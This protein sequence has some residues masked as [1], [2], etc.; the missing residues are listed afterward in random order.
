VPIRDAADEF[1]SLDKC[2]MDQ[3]QKSSA[4][5]AKSPMIR[6]AA[7]TTDAGLSAMSS[8]LAHLDPAAGAGEPAAFA[9]RAYQNQ[10]VQ[11][12]LGIASGLFA[13]LRARHAPT[14][15]HSLRVALGCSSWAIFQDISDDERD[16]IEVAALLHDL[17][18]VGVPD[19]ILIKPGRLTAEESRIMDRHRQMGWEILQTC[20]VSPLL[21]SIMRNCGARFD[22][23]RPGYE[24]QGEELPLG[25]RM[26]AIVDAFDAMTN[27]QIYR[28]ALSR[29]RSIAEL[30]EHAGSQFDPRL[31]KDFCVFIGS[32]QATLQTAVAHRWLKQLQASSS[33]KMWLLRDGPLAAEAEHG[34]SF[35]QQLLENMHDAVIFV[36]HSQRILLWNRA[37][38]RLTGISTASV[39]QQ[40]WSPELI[41][42]RD[43]SRQPVSAVNCPLFRAI[44][45]GQPG[46][47][48]MTIAGRGSERLDVDAHVVPVRNQAGVGQ[49][50]ALLLHDASSQISL[51]Q[52]VLSLHEKAI[53]DPL[54]QV[55]NRAEFDR[56]QEICLDSHAQRQVPCSL[57]MC[58]L[59]HFKQV[60]DTYGH[61]AG[62][63]VLISFAAL[64]QR[65]CRPGD[66][67]ARYGG[68]EFVL[69]CVDCN[70][71]AATRRAE[72]LRTEL[73]RMTLD[74]L[75]GK[76]ITASFG[77]TELQNGDTSETMLRRADRALYQAKESGRNLVVQLGAGIGD[78]KPFR[79]RTGWLA[80]LCGR[81]PERIL[82]RTLITAVPLNVVVEKVRG[83]VAD[84]SAQIESVGEN[85]VVLRIA[86]S[87]S[88][89]LRRT[90][91]RDV[92]FVIEL[93]FDEAPTPADNRGGSG[94]LRTVVRVT[95]RPQR[96]RDR[97]RN[98]ALP[99]A[100]KLLASLKSYLIAHEYD[101]SLELAPSA[102]KT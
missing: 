2:T 33:N 81:G 8:L 88:L 12:R 77:V 87:E 20:S 75:G 52:R 83:F 5:D 40:K 82:S 55:S 53:R 24:L 39:E 17:G 92:P 10:L 3:P 56:I 1:A 7:L 97:R 6:D 70:N 74:A 4:R 44:R 95:I 80:W 54:T 60:N 21:L 69:L 66:L 102:L 99:R 26:L 37:A 22:G 28:G 98:E 86:G 25:A 32:H 45:S 72:Q 57:I 43:K 38:E 41:G 46:L 89:F 13:T 76:T 36:D 100:Q 59:D 47:E 51:E 85:H 73:S 18:K 96:G 49:G 65:H 94:V 31:V 62:D 64:L 30:F 35:Q 42:L 34:D 67:V 48:R 79:D 63:E 9:E 84:Q 29:E 68:E 78:E 91:D 90:A 93:K 16:E 50:A 19:E 14:A 23:T 58:D 15:A 61:Q 71:A 11:V 27:D 101:G